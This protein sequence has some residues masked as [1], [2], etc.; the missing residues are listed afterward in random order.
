MMNF[1]INNDVAGK[2]PGLTKRLLVIFICLVCLLMPQAAYP[3]CD[4]GYGDGQFTSA[5]GIDIDGSMGDWANV[6]ADPDNN[7][8]DGGS[9]NVEPQPDRDAPVQSTGRDL[10]HFAYAWDD[11]GVYTYTVR[12]GSISNVQRFIYYAD[13][14]N[15]GLMETGETVI[16]AQ[17]KGSNRDVKLYLGT[18][19]ASAPGGDP[20]SDA[21]GYAD[22][23]SLPGTVEGLASPGN[24]DSR[25]KWGNNGT[26]MEWMIT[27]EDLGVPPGTAFTYHLGSTNSQPGAGS[28]PGQLD[29][30]M[31][32]CG[33]RV[34][35]TQYANLVFYPDRSLQISQAAPAHASHTLIN[36]GNGAD[37][38]NFTSTTSGG[39]SPTISYYHD[40]DS[41]GT[42][43]AGDTLLT[44]TDGD[45]S[46][47]T[48]LIPSGEIMDVLIAYSI[49]GPGSGIA[50]VQTTATSA[51]DPNWSD[52][53]TDT[54]TLVKLPDIVMLKSVMVYSDPVNGTTNPKAIP[55]AEMIYTIQVTNHGDGSV[56]PDTIVII[57]P[58]PAN[59]EMFVADIGGGSGPVDFSDGAV[60]SG[61][62]YSYIDPSSPLDSID[63]SSDGGATYGY[64][65]SPDAD[66][67]DSGVNAIRITPSGPFLAS[68]GINDPSFQI[69]FRV[70]LY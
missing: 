65:P 25:G 50:T 18:Y 69:R 27:W 29:D 43:T 2:M 14:D 42:F 34:G 56:D 53:V 62:T 52:I 7:A 10:I 41:S 31:S 17:W 70:R 12:S 67:Y 35:G 64:A 30:N 60:S 15:D 39:F 51:Y 9:P 68:D 61:L 49:V 26:A 47:D 21:D 66:G 37:T 57:D 45:G 28:F 16:V 22:G 59:T 48:G 38:F 46:P 20:M 24:P 8:C 13:I 63:F 44:D 23:Y 5:Q 6:L 4:C 1:S 54:L 11:I 33:G 3:V 58:I 40:V 55:G 19:V 32:G 36:T